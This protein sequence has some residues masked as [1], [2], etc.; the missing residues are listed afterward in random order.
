MSISSNIPSELRLP[1]PVNTNPNEIDATETQHDSD[2]IETIPLSHP[3][4]DLD[5]SFETR[6]SIDTDASHD[7]HTPMNNNDL[8]MSLDSAG[9]M[10]SDELNVTIDSQDADTT[11]ESIGSLGSTGGKHRKKRTVKNNKTANEK[12]TLHLK[13]YC[14]HKEVNNGKYIKINKTRRH[15]LSWN[16]KKYRF[17]TCCKAC[18]EEMMK[19]KKTNPEKFKK[20]YIYSIDLSLIHI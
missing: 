16:G 11:Q 19:L 17:Y 18:C 13:K 5:E 12:M 10:D 20:T 15:T 7:I 9:T 8:N 6:L 14:P 1:I 4:D 2:I 3:H